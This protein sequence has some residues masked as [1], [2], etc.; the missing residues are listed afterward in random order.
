[1]KRRFAGGCAGYVHSTTRGALAYRWMRRMDVQLVTAAT[2][3]L[4]LSA[5]SGNRKS[6]A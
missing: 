2:L 4:R 3:D 6:C 5:D 1:M